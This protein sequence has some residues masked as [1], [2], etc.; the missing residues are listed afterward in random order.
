MELQGTSTL[1]LLAVEFAGLR[2]ALEVAKHGTV[3]SNYKAEPHESN[4]NYAQVGVSAVLS[5]LDSVESGLPEGPERIRE[6]IQ[7]VQSFDHGEDGNLHLAR[8]GGHSHHRIVVRFISKVTFLASGGAGHIYPD[9]NESSGSNWRWSC[10]GPS[11]SSSDS[12]Y[13]VSNFLAP[14]KMQFLITEAVRG[15]GVILY[16]LDRKDS[17]L[18][19]MIERSL[20]KGCGGKEHR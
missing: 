1:Q 20:P 17:C 6:L 4:T 9:Y 11:S 15:D 14:E 10:D 5:P 12:K 3:C 2:Y 18:F 13:G 8:E 7:W 16:N 19:M